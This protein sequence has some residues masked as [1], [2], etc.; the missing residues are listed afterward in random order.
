MGTG[1]DDEVLLNLL[2]CCGSVVKWKRTTDP[3]SGESKA[4]GF[5]DYSTGES[6][7]RAMRLLASLPLGEGGASHQLL[8]KVNADTQ[9]FL[10]AYEPEMRAHLGWLR[11]SAQSQGAAEITP[12]EEERDTQAAARIEGVLGERGIIPVAAAAAVGAAAVAAAPMDESSRNASMA[13][14]LLSFQ[15]GEVAKATLVVPPPPPAPVLSAEQLAERKE[16]ER[17]RREADFDERLRDKERDEKRR[18]PRGQVPP[19]AVPPSSAPAPPQG[20]PGGS[21]QLGTPSLRTSHW[22]AC[23]C[24]GCSSEPP[25]KSPISLRFTTSRHRAKLPHLRHGGR[26]QLRCE[27]MHRL[28]L[29]T[30]NLP[31]A[32]R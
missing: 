20:A 27:R 24:L 12:S 4:F 8:L 3:V 19:L 31:L 30:V 28:L 22:N 6:V 25:P 23:H 17:A 15:P 13:D 29:L 18:E 2:Q 26:R 32:Y 16:R 21:G 14:Q 7:L 11:A 5:C 1:I 10:T 9:T